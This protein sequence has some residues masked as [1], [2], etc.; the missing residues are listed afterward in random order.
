MKAI[1]NLEK[2][3]ES[4]R[5]TVLNTSKIQKWKQFTTQTSIT[6]NFRKLSSIRQR[7][8]NES[9]SQ[10]LQV[11]QIFKSHCPQ[12]VKDTKMKAIHNVPARMCRHFLTVLNTSKI[13]KW[14]QFTTGQMKSKVH[15]RLSSIR[16]RYKNESNSQRF[17]RVG[18]I[19]GN[20]PQYVK[21]TK[22]KAIHNTPTGGDYAFRTVLNTSKIQKWKQFTT[23]SK[24]IYT[25]IWLSSIRQRYK[26]ESNSQLTFWPPF[27]PP[28]CPQYVKD[29]KMKAIHNGNGYNG[30]S[31]FTV[32]NTSKIQKWKQ[33]TTII[34]RY[35]ACIVLSS[36]RQR[37]KNES[38]SQQNVL[39]YAAVI[40][41]PQYVKDTKMKAI[42]NQLNG[43]T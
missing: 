37:Y 43:I 13:Q 17:R 25:I 6:L 18:F 26:N 22:M 35:F 9:N 19:P 34:N 12:Y 23:I 8:K 10:H 16:Q 5:G 14:K 41:C 4:Q 33:F 15:L 28:Y 1:H 39:S 30:R 38:N 3:A 21:D 36:I 42:H 24:N 29:T 27:L 31:F 40:D 11:H 2:A 20:C 7:Y 32:L